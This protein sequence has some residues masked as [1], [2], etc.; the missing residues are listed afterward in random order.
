MS[1]V[2]PRATRP[3]STSMSPATSAQPSATSRRAT[4]APMPRPAPVTITDLHVDGSSRLAPIAPPRSPSSASRYTGGIPEEGVLVRR[5]LD[6]GQPVRAEPLAEATADHDRLDVEQRHRRPDADAERLDG[7]QD[8]GL[9]HL[10][11]GLQRPQPDPAREPVAA[12]LLHQ[13]EKDGRT[14]LRR[15]PAPAPRAPPGPH[16]PPR[17]P[18]AHSCSAGRQAWR[19]RGRSHPPTHDR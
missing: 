18:R 9:G 14:V 10:V 8:E 11:A 19:R 3:T 6:P 5:S 1:E 12:A 7:A 15:A 17:I 2:R 4:A 13:L 16:M